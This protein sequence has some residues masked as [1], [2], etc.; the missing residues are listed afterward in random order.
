MA[1]QKNQLAM[2]RIKQLIDSLR[3]AIKLSRIP[4]M[5]QRLARLRHWWHGLPGRRRCVAQMSV[6]S[7]SPPVGTG[8]PMTNL[9]FSN[10][11]RQGSSDL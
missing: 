4:L 3:A 7:D 5:L 2:Q 6:T 11:V 1:A 8:F 9:Q 10:Y